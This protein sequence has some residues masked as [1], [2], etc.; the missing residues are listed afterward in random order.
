MA[1]G[2]GMMLTAAVPGSRP[3]AGGSRPTR[4]PPRPIHLGSP[5]RYA[6]RWSHID[7]AQGFA[8]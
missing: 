6:S 2:I 7:S 8:S 5:G 3:A 1:A 4:Y